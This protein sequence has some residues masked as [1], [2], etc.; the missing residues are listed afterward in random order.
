MIALSN[1]H[2][3]RLRHTAAAVLLALLLVA[4]CST[5]PDIT[6]Y[7]TVTSEVDS[8]V[9]DFHDLVVADLKGISAHARSFTENEGQLYD[10]Q[11]LDDAIVAFSVEW[12]KRRAVTEAMVTYSNSLATIVQE[13]KSG[14]ES[15]RELAKAAGGFLKVVPN[16]SSIPENVIDVVA[17]LKGQLDAIEANEKLY[18]AV[19]DAQPIVDQIADILI[20]DFDIVAD[21]LGTIAPTA[22]LLIAMEY[23]G[24]PAFHE[25][26]LRRQKEV[27][28]RIIAADDTGA[29]TADDVKL[30]QEI[31][32]IIA[33][34]ELSY[35]DYSEADQRVERRAELEVLAVERAKEAVRQWQQLHH[36]LVANLRDQTEP[37][38][39][40]FRD[41]AAELR[42]IVEHLQEDA[43]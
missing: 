21:R 42:E 29:D 43:G 36:E 40:S 14:A 22:Q 3:C 19:D 38:V 32:T 1:C 2:R 27:V 9:N 7:A 33:A 23:G 12:K 8:A 24:L 39:A 25:K 15:V 31:G 11:A 6:P 37:S 16:L 4:G 10:T 18:D 20:D 35:R 28:N 41:T 5:L 17:F 30:L 26:Q 13:G 34:T